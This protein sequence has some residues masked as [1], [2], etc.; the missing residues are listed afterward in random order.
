MTGT[1]HWLLGT[2]FFLFRDVMELRVERLQLCTF[3][4]CWVLLIPYESSI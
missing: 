2:T 4:D 3:D 1:G